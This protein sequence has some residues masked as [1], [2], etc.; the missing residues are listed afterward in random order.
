VRHFV[1]GLKFGIKETV[2][3][4]GPASFLQAV[5]KAKEVEQAYELGDN[6]PPLEGLT[7]KIEDQ[8]VRAVRQE[9]NHLKASVRKRE[10]WENRRST[11]RPEQRAP[12][13]E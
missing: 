4:S 7:G 5:K 9:M 10:A 1:R 11:N 3:A 6:R 12:P 13:R 2:M 8:V